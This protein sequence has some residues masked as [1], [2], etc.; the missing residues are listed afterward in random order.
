MDGVILLRVEH[1]YSGLNRL[2]LTT[3][4]TDWKDWRKY[5]LIVKQITAGPTDWELTDWLTDGHAD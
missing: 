2:T 3:G 4:H 1:T 5:W